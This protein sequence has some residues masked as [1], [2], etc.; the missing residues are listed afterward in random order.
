MA[1]N[2]P[3]TTTC[4]WTAGPVPAGTVFVMGDNRDNSDDSSMHLCQPKARPPTARRTPFVPVDDVVGKVFALLWPHEPLPSARTVPPTSPD[5]SLERVD[6]RGCRAE[7]PSGATPGSTATSARCAGSGMDLVAGVDE[8]GRGA[9]A[10][11]LVAG[12]AILRPRARPAS[13]RAGRLQ[14]AHREGP[15]ALLRPDPAGGRC[16]GRWW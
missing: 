5:A 4:N 3:M 2:G 12:A 11:P 15:G 14:A 6:D 7:R 10:G 1:C 8:A 9:C 13:A 16:R